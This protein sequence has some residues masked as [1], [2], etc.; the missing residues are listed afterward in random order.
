[1]AV[2]ILFDFVYKI[3]CLTFFFPD[4][5]AAI[6]MLVACILGSFL[7]NVHH[8]ASPMEIQAA[9]HAAVSVIGCSVQ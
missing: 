1:M 2:I 9:G 8:P 3:L 7:L 4:G 6:H 5:V